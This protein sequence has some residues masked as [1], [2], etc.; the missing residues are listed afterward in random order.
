VKF[1]PP[2]VIVI[3]GKYIITDFFWP[4]NFPSLPIQS[5]ASCLQHITILIPWLGLLKHLSLLSTTVTTY[6]RPTH[7]F[8]HLLCCWVASIFNITLLLI[9]LVEK[10]EYMFLNVAEWEITR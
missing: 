4:V 9:L 5:P 6:H 3:N 8:N 7:P 1:S 2:M 10:T